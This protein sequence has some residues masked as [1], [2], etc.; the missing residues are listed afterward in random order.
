MVVTGPPPPEA[1]PPRGAPYD[2]RPENRA[3]LDLLDMAP[4]D[5]D[6]MLAEVTA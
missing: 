1:L 4:F 6:T 3:T 5:L 2:T